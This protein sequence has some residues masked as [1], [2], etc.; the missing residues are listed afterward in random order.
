MAT[1]AAI[2]I[3]ATLAAIIIMATLAACVARLVLVAASRVLQR[4]LQ[5]APRTTGRASSKPPHRV[6]Q[7]LAYSCSESTGEKSFFPLKRV[8][9]PH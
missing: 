1:L 6:L 5:I 7:A 2:I 4:R 3:M 9:F 8:F